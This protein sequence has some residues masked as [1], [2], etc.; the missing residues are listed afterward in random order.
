MIATVKK[1]NLTESGGSGESSGSSDDGGN[2]NNGAPFVFSNPYR[3]G[4]RLMGLDKFPTF[5]PRGYNPEGNTW[6]TACAPI[7]SGRPSGK[8][9]MPGV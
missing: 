2:L 8:S 6:R 7:G 3:D 1:T 5:Y 9:T 4:G